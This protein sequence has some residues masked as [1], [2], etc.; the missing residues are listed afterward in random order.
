M[1][2]DLLSLPLSL[3][4]AFRMVATTGG[5]TAAAGPLGMTPSAVSQKVRQL[6]AL[7]GARLFERTSRSVR[8][9]EAGKTLLAGTQRPFEELSTA[10]D[11][12]R[13]HDGGPAELDRHAVIRFRFPESRRL[14]SLD[15][16]IGGQVLQLDPPA[17]LVLDDNAHIAQAVREGL[18]IAQRFRVTEEAAI[19]AGEVVEV[20]EAFEPEPLQFH[21]YYPS[22]RQPA[23]LQAF[24][25]W[26][27][28]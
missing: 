19:A 28:G 22:R 25:D 23:K 4:P 21:L 10:I 14:K 1:T 15:F 13:A 26:F 16:R 18:G 11:Q 8:L 5:F 7:L 27:A 17:C 12:V 6:E 24:I 20:L 9:T 3:L 2:T